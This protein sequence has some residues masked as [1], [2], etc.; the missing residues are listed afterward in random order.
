SNF[1]TI[2]I[3]VPSGCTVELFGCTEKLRFHVGG[4]RAP[5]A[6]FPEQLW[7]A[8]SSPSRQERRCATNCAGSHARARGRQKAWSSTCR[9]LSRSGPG[10]CLEYFFGTATKSSLIWLFICP[11]SSFSAHESVERASDA[12]RGRSRCCSS[13]TSAII[14]QLHS[15]QL[16]GC[17]S[18]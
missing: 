14:S 18:C 11:A 17:G 8:S 6:S 2:K 16:P 3:K 7:N 5:W 13:N 1:T 12:P 15:A 9:G 10:R 4:R